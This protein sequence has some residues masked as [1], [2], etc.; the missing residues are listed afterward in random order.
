M[1]LNLF[2]YIGCLVCVHYWLGVG[3]IINEFSLYQI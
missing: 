1:T 3:F 2:D